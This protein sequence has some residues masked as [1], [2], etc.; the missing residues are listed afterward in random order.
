MATPNFSRISSASIS[1]R[2]ITGICF[3]LAAMTSGFCADTAEEMTTTWASPTFD[4]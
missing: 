2:G 4:S 3:A 1:A